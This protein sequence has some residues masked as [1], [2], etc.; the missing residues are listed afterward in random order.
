MITIACSRAQGEIRADAR[1]SNFTLTSVCVCVCVCV[2]LARASFR[3]ID[4]AARKKASI[5]EKSRA[6]RG[7]LEAAR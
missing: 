7:L 6:S 5:A 3:D 2:S 4:L 1:G